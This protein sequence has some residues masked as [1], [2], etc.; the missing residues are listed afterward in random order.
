MLLFF[1]LYLL[2]LVA[3]P[4]RDVPPAK[5]TVRSCP[6]S[7]ND[8]PHGKKTSSNKKKNASAKSGA[9]IEL[10]VSPLDIQ[11]Y[12][13]SYSRRENWG[14]TD[15]QLTLDSWTF[16]L[17]LVKEELFRDT[18]AESNPKGVEWTGGSVRVHI[19]TLQL[20][21]GY[22]RTIVR[23]MFRGHGRATDQFAMQKE[24]WE[25]DSSNVFET[26]VVSAL[27]SHFVSP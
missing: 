14:I 1:A 7:W 20:T 15:D 24:Y 25:L 10:A 2:F 8:A 16:S 27:R 21:D 26:S 5:P 3:R 23:A 22:A 12:L 17:E 6:D 9:C 11:E 13:Q 19:N 4:A 18:V